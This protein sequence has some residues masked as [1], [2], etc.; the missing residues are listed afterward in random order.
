MS[1]VIK[2]AL[3]VAI[4]WVLL[5]LAA[6]L[7]QRRLMYFP[8]RERIPPAAAGLF[9][10]AEKVLATPDGERVVAW[11][12]KAA[13]GQPTLLYFHGNGGGLLER[14]ERIR[15]FRR[16]GWGVL[17]MAYRGYAGSSG[18]PSERANLADGR[19]AYGALLA[20]GVAQ[21]DIILYGESIGTGVAAH[22]AAELPAGGLVLE[23]PF[24]SAVEV[25]ARAYPFLPVSL[26]LKDRYETRNCIGRVRMP[27]L[28]LHGEQDNTI[29]VAMARELFRLANEPKRLATFPA[30]GHSD[31]YLDGNGA[32]AVVKDWLAGVRAAGGP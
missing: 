32:L 20:E 13:A 23:A 22:L 6:Y 16:E 29:P 1:L 2:L 15:R 31:L 28:I 10:V 30:G 8:N 9:E 4:G 26:L 24:T 27:L 3:I 11:T 25:G 19:L 21:K 18:S 5:G 12:G 17:L 7:G 14:A